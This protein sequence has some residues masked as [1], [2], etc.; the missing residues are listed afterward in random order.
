MTADLRSV[1]ARVTVRCWL[2]G[3]K[4]R[5]SVWTMRPVVGTRRMVATYGTC[6]EPFAGGTCGGT[7]HRDVERRFILR[8]ATNHER[9]GGNVR[10]EYDT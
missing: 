1:G 4:R 10:S 6:R 9:R 5:R 3:A 7:M 8:A 2:C